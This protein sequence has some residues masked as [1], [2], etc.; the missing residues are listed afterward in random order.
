MK[1]SIAAG[2]LTAVLLFLIP[3]VTACLGWDGG[4]R[5]FFLPQYVVRRPQLMGSENKFH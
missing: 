3:F 4:G 5:D 1:A 2:Y